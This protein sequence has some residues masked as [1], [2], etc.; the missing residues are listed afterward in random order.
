MD[1]GFVA[2]LIF[3]VVLLSGVGMILGELYM[4]RWGIC[5]KSWPST[6]G[7]IIQSELVEEWSETFPLGG[8]D[9]YW[10]PKITYTYI[11]DGEKL[12]GNRI[13]FSSSFSLQLSAQRVVNR[14]PLNSKVKVYYNPRNPS[15]AV[16][17]P[18][19]TVGMYCLIIGGVALIILGVSLIIFII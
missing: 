5:S 8:F 2:I 6:T 13:N 3:A 12:Q 9:S 17:K 1:F 15:D 14:Y 19:S 7:T 16:L 11:V 18:G 4:V 10:M